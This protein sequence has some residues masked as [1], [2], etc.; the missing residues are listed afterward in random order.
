MTFGSGTHR[1][2]ATEDLS[3]PTLRTGRFF[4]SG[5]EYHFRRQISLKRSVGQASRA[6]ESRKLC[7]K[8]TSFFMTFGS[9]THRFRATE[10][11]SGPT[12]KMGR[13]F[14]FRRKI[15]L[16]PTFH[17][18]KLLKPKVADTIGLC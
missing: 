17:A 4:L 3:T 11:L 10:D 9:G 12:P 16:Q 1:F 15:S 5:K 6:R 14:G 8:M 18:Q 13:F 2:R 7:P